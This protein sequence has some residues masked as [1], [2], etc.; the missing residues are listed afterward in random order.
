MPLLTNKILFISKN[1]GKIQEAQEILGSNINIIPEEYDISEIQTENFETLVRDKVL[2][3]YAKYMRPLFVEHTGLQI[4][5][6]NNLP[7]GLTQVFWDTLEAE[8]F[9]ELFEG[10]N[11]KAVT[12]I[13]YIDGKTIKLFSGDISGKI[14]KV[15]GDKTFQW[16]CVFQ[17]E[18]Y[19]KTFAELGKEKNEI[20]MRKKALVKFSKYLNIS[21]DVK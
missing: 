13:G 10:S 20:S 6:I 18:G 8:K 12:T 15:R 7:G 5:S 2:K 1:K 9:G 17:P 4:E 19:T 11:V 14:V 3:A 21:E 16:D